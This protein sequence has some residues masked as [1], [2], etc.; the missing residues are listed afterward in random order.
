MPYTN[1][2]LPPSDL[3]LFWVC[4]A[5]YKAGLEQMLLMAT[6]LLFHFA[7]YHRMFGHLMQ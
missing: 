1:I 6:R 5:A 3:R 2:L 4:A 7:L